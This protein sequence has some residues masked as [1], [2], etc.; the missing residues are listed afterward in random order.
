MRL[1]IWAH[2]GH[3]TKDLPENSVEAIQSAIEYGA[4]GVEI[5][6]QRTKDGE[7]V[8]IH[9]E[10]LERLTGLNRFVWE[11]EYEDL[12]TLYLLDSEKNTTKYHVPKLT[13]VLDLFVGEKTK[14][15]IEIKDSFYPYK[16]LPAEVVKEVASRNLQEQVIY[17]SFNHNTIKYLVD[18]GLGDYSGFLYGEI[19]YKPAAYAKSIGAKYIHPAGT[20]LLIDNYVEDTTAAGF[21]LNVWTLN[22]DEH[23]K[24]ALDK[25]INAIIT[26]ELIRAMQ[27]RDDFV[28]Q[29]EG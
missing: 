8:V 12:K 23:I 26:D 7:L 28:S 18:Q 20:N 15:N 2:R 4:D 5:D 25:N 6:V 3:H 10:Y 21:L 22:S 9:D 11:V 19:I 14:L 13:E 16:N 24:F 29:K 17:S 1:E 27:I